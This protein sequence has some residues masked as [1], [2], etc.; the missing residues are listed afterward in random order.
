MPDVRGVTAGSD[1]MIGIYG[2]TFDPVHIGHLR[3][4]QEVLERLE[5]PDFRF[6]PAANPPH[7]ETG[8][9][10]ARHRLA[11]LQLATEGQPR[12]SID[13]REFH[14]AGPSYMVDTLRDLRSE[15]P[16][17]PLLLIIGQDSAN[18]LDRWHRWSELFQLAHIV[19][20]QRP[21][22]AGAYSIELSREMKSRSVSSAQSLAGNTH[23]SV[24]GLEVTQLSVSSS[25]IRKMMRTG[26]SPR[27]LVPDRVLEYI[28]SERIYGPVPG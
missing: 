19:V 10:E 8:V 24:F 11:M 25:G 17:S 2:G 1:N 23:G 4:A 16:A 3:T 15:A 18:S 27:Y 9:T 28:R 14:R 6:L 7:R 21:D 22:H 20:M 13:Q 26:H 12:F 5:I